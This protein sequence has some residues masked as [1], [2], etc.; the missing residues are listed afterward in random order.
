M[1]NPAYLSCLA[2]QFESQGCAAGLDPLQAGRNN[3]DLNDESRG[4]IHSPLHK[5]THK[6]TRKPSTSADINKKDTQEFAYRACSSLATHTSAN[7]GCIAGRGPA[8]GDRNGQGLPLETKNGKRK[9][10][11][12]NP[13]FYGI[14][15]KKKRSKTKNQHNKE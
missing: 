13:K 15:S 4:Y 9:K 3:Q 10:K 12:C 11:R 2:M 8:M 1:A 6:H 5:H 14:A 7:Q